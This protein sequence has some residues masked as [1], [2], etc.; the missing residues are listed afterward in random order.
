MISH[1]RS[2]LQPS[3]GNKVSSNFVTVMDGN[4]GCSFHKDAKNCRWPSYD[5]TC[6]IATTVKSEETGRLYR[7][8]T[9][10]NSRA[11]CGRAMEGEIKFTAFKRGLETEMARIDS[12]YKEIYG[13]GPDVPTARTYT[14]LY[15]NKIAIGVLWLVDLKST[16]TLCMFSSMVCV[17]D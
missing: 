3:S 8:V 16:S 12:S 1:E 17:R 11:A 9:N 2:P 15:S 4:D 6:C 13:N 14:E 7:A 5:W 10:L